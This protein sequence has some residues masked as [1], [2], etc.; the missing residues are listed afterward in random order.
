MADESSL[1]IFDELS[2]TSTSHSKV[3]SEMGKE[4]V[5][6]KRPRTSIKTLTASCSL[7]DSQNIS[8]TLSRTCEKSVNLVLGESQHDDVCSLSL[9]MLDQVNIYTIILLFLR[10]PENPFIKTS[11]YFSGIS[12]LG[13]AFVSTLVR[14]TSRS[15]I[16]VYSTLRWPWTPRKSTPLSMVFR[17]RFRN[18]S[19]PPEVG[20]VLTLHSS[21]N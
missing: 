1:S 15:T 18:Y 3:D 4:N 13:T 20:F 6:L 8:A 19:P 12:R 2:F 17:P 10:I 5:S 21:W 11:V 9:S 7:L 14:M 16:R